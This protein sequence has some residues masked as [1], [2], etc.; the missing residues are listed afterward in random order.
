[1]YLKIIFIIK[2]ILAL[3][4]IISYIGI[5]L[6][7]QFSPKFKKYRKTLNTIFRIGISVL[8]ISAQFPQ[9]YNVL[10]SESKLDEKISP[11][12]VSAGIIILLTIT[13]EDINQVKST[14]N[15]RK[16]HFNNNLN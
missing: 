4:L 1:M 13:Q 11:I 6:K 5:F 10:T 15:L 7:I 9:L 3:L 2:T 16:V 8:L 12:M 14:F